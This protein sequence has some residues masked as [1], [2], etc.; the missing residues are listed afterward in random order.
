MPV[1]RHDM[2]ESAQFAITMAQ[3]SHQ[4]LS[5]SLV[6]LLDLFELLDGVRD[7]MSL[8]DSVWICL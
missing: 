1:A 6:S 3:S 5:A 8:L 2:H 7:F 4:E